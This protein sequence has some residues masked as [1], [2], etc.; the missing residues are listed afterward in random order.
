MLQ[1]DTKHEWR[2]RGNANNLQNLSK[3]DDFGSAAV[4][5]ALNGSESAQF[6][7]VGDDGVSGGVGMP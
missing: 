1:M 3:K 4:T 6:K 2:G 5:P 7:S